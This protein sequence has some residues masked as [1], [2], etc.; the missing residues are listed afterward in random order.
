MNAPVDMTCNQCCAAMIQGVYCHETGCPNQH[1][2]KVDGEWIAPEPESDEYEDASEDTYC[3]G[4]NHL[5]S[6]STDSAIACTQCCDGS[7]W[8]DEIE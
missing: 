8:T 1:K 6:D 5:W 3:H 2:M 4:C 7:E